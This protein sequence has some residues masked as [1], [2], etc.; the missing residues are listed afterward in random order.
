[1]SEQRADGSEGGHVLVAEDDR[2]YRQILAKRL[3]A[4]GYR[5]TLTGDGQEAW[6][7][8]EEEAPDLLLSDWMMPR[9][10]GQELCARVKSH[11]THKSIY[12]I[13]LTAKDQMD[14]RV[15][16]LDFGA[17]EYIVKPCDDRE[18][19][20]R[21]RAG[22][23][24]RRLTRQLEEDSVTDALTSLRNRRYLDRR[25]AEEAARSRRSCAPLS[26]VLLDLDHF[27][28]VNDRY[29]HPAGDEV[30]ARVA[31]V[32]R[33][34]IRLGEVAAR[35][36]GDEF[37]VLL[38]NTNLDGAEAFS[39][40][41]EEAIAALRFDRTACVGLTLGCS[42]GCAEFDPEGEISTLIK[43]ADDALYARKQEQRVSSGS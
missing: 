25:L 15:A 33:N 26:L 42:A 21:V 7:A 37:A 16:A 14:D 31:H 8:I 18:L 11:P 4:A 19:M 39:R 27:K 43:D 28:A 13:L 40:W 17:D 6:E 22:L 38:P 41:I 36:G 24:T 2:F 34:R 30:L 23:R 35:I 10:D 20:A 29:G 1:L 9:V 32:L 5:V 12:C 3:E